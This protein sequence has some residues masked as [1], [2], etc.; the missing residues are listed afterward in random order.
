MLKSVK[1]KILSAILVPIIIINLIFSF[2]LFYFANMLI[3]EYIEPEFRDNLTLKLDKISNSYTQQAILEGIED[4]E[5]RKVLL[6]T[7]RALQKQYELEYVYIQILVDGKELSFFSSETDET[8]DPYAFDEDQYK[9]L[10]NPNDIVLTDMYDDDYGTHLSAYKGIE[11]ANA[12]IGIDVD[13]SFIKKMNTNLLIVCIGLFSTFVLIGIATAF[14]MARKM[15]KPLHELVT[16]TGFVSEGDLTQEITVKTNDEIGQLGESFKDMQQQ[17]RQTIADVS[18]TTDT[19]IGGANH[20]VVNMEELAQSADQVT[21]AV[22]EIATNSDV[23]ATGAA[24]NKI[25]VENITNAILDISETTESVSTE[26]NKAFEQSQKGNATIQLSVRGIASIQQ[27]AR[28]SLDKTEQMNNRSG[29]VSQIIQIITGISDQIN[30]LALNAAIEA[31]RAGEYGKGFAVVADEVR[32]LAEQSKESAANISSLIEVMQQDS[33]AS[34]DAIIKV[35][36]EVDGEMA[37]IQTAGE[38]FSYIANLINVIKQQVLKMTSEI[39]MISAS[40]EEVLATTNESVESVATTASHTK[41]IAGSVEELTA[42][43][44]EMLSVATSLQNAANGLDE[45]MHRFKY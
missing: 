40:S 31:A 18:V 13:A 43:L 38:V 1:L 29:E 39:Q 45:K 22:Q 4:E 12:V 7:A 16:Y 23:V 6:K 32:N 33:N 2:S 28:V 3:K 17:L 20:L 11:G 21:N 30:L 19:V 34:V 26:I 9:A 44:Q 24:Q 10:D 36:N 37:N 42:S 15:T 5:K 35:V 8:M 14:I 25:A 41:L 27:T